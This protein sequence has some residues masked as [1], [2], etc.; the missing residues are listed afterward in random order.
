MTFISVHHMLHFETN[1]FQ[2]WT[3]PLHVSEMEL[4]L[5]LRIAKRKKII[6]NGPYKNKDSIIKAIEN[7]VII[8]I[9]N[10]DELVVIN[11]FLKHRKDLRCNVGIRINLSID[12]E[13]LSRFGIKPYKT[14]FKLNVGINLCSWSNS[15]LM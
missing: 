5:A 9:D 7:G 12:Q 4:D 6:F 13:Q 3:P 15:L 14:L 11:D 1:L 2:S 10:I 8:H